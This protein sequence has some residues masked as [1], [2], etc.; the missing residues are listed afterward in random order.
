MGRLGVE[1]VTTVFHLGGGGEE[2]LELRDLIQKGILLG[3]RL[4]VGKLIDGPTEA[5][6]DDLHKRPPPSSIEQP[7]TAADGRAAVDLAVAN[8]YDFIKSYQHLNQE[9]YDAVEAAAHAAGLI[10]VGHLP[11]IGCRTCVS[12]EHPFLVPMN[13]PVHPSLLCSGRGDNSCAWERAGAM[14]NALKGNS[15]MSC[16]KLLVYKCLL[17]EVA[18]VVAAGDQSRALSE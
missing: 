11:E 3:P 14:S 13:D 5:V 8:H 1:G 7:E 16:L 6:V 4:V 18:P 10:T 15:A 17:V 12:R 9:S 2:V